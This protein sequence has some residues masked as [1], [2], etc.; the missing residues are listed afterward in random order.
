[1]PL[2][3]SLINDVKVNPEE[4]AV[5]GNK[6]ELVLSDDTQTLQF[7]RETEFKRLDLLTVP[8]G[9]SEEEETRSAMTYRINS[10]I[11]QTSM[12]E[13][14]IKDILALVQEHNPALLTEIWHGIDPVKEQAV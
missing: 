6:I 11:Q 3:R 7:Y 9:M 4:M 14:R 12:V 13:E 5:N 8:I 2:I 1:M 10:T